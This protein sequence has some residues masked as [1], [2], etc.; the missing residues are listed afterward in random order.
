MLFLPA[1][2]LTPMFPFFRIN[3]PTENTTGC[4]MN[5]GRVIPSVDESQLAIIDYLHKV[6]GR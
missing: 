4:V 3:T 1:M 5:C 6:T 2:L